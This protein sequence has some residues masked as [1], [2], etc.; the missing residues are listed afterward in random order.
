[1]PIYTH[2]KPF[3]RQCLPGGRPVRSLGATALCAILL[4]GCGAEVATQ[5]RSD[6]PVSGGTLIYATDRE[7]TCLDPHVAGDMPQLFVARQ[8]LDSLVSMNEQ[9]EIGPWLAKSWEVSEDGRTYTFH[10]RDDVR[11]TDGTSFNAQALKANLEHIVNPK[12]QSSTAG[13]YIRQYV[14]TDIIDEYTAAVRLNAPY[15]AFLEVLAQGFLGIQSPA[16]LQRS[17]DE[18]CQSPVG[19]GPFKVVRWERQNQ[20][21]LERNSAYNSAPPT[22]W[23]Q[24]PAYLERIQWKFI[25]EPSVRFA[26]LQ[27]G[28]VDV[29]ETLP[30]ESH[31][32]AR[33]NP[34]LQLIIAQRPGN[35]TNGTLNI[36]RAPFDDVRVREAFVRSADVEGALKSVYFGEFPRSG[37][38]LSSATRFFS[39]DFEAAQAYDPKRAAELLDEAGWTQRDEQ[40]YRTRDGKRLH[41]NVVIGSRTAPSELTLWEQVQ[42]T[43]RQAGID[44][45]LEQMSDVQ[46]TKRQAD[47]EYD[48]RIGYWNTNTA[49][50]LRIVFG[51]EF[52]QPA[53]VGGYH[54][55]TAGFADPDFDS[56]MKAA[57]ATQDASA[58]ARL[59]YQA[60]AIISRQYLQLTTY[61]QSTRLGIYKTTQGVHLEPSLAVPYL[62]DAWVNK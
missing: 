40:G 52:V 54:Q 20:V 24:G 34:D 27:A 4:A 59:Y 38:P 31:E 26:S 56:V 23:H 49:D 35:P 44:V 62:Y 57:L 48:I 28:E 39:A 21:L 6:Q 36:T 7:P 10:L 17:R 46:A 29:I 1:M 22:A 25:Q 19:S 32:A 9:G 50:V 2:C 53:G 14:D 42:A 41:V 47:W 33:R 15:A 5:A 60:Q 30:P 58:R 13:G 43:A 61:P 18:N 37:G 11:F 51:S 55:N 16:A 12:T 8:F 45:Q 3:A